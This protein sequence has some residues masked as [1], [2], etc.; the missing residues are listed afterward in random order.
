MGLFPFQMASMAYKIGVTNHLLNGMIL[1]VEIKF[2]SWDV[3]SKSTFR[4]L[5]LYILIGLVGG[6]LSLTGTWKY[7]KA[8]LPKFNQVW[9]LKK[10]DWKLTS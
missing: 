10:M 7:P 1:Q 5:F 6:I 9:K 2:T 8:Y 3:E 4:W